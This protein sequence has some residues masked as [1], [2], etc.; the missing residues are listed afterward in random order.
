MDHLRQVRSQ[1]LLVMNAGPR[2]VWVAEH[3]FLLSLG[4]SD[5]GHC[6]LGPMLPSCRARRDA[7]SPQ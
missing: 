2:G 3:R 6:N 4:S 1:S 7:M 5:G